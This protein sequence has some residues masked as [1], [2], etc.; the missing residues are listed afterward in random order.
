MPQLQPPYGPASSWPLSTASV[1]TCSRQKPKASRPP[2]TAAWLMKE[3]KK[4][5]H[6]IE[7]E[8]QTFCTDPGPG[9]WRDSQRGR[10]SGQERVGCAQSHLGSTTPDP[11][12]HLDITQI[13]CH[14]Q[15]MVIDF[16]GASV[17]VHTTVTWARSL[18]R[19]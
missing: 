13:T 18:N 10:G 9:Q 8:L 15:P 4:C 6:H 1:N 14:P 19:S 5:N 17:C 16:L 7:P 3:K 11:P 12:C 2:P